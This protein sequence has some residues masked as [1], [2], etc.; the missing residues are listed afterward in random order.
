M[1]ETPV[2]PNV[3]CENRLEFNG[4]QIMLTSIIQNLQT[5]QSD[6]SYEVEIN[7]DFM[8]DRLN[9]LAHMCKS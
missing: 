3:V 6:N 2:A 5:P 7:F 4:N 9:Y 1:N 8:T